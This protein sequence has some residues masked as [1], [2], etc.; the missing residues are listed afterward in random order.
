MAG[1]PGRA[2]YVKIGTHAVVPGIH[3]CGIASIGGNMITLE[4]VV[5][6]FEVR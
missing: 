6:F 1:L 5:P 3:P 2:G 4:Q